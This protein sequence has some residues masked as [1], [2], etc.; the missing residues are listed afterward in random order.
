MFQLERSE[1]Q[2]LRCQIGILEKG[3]HAKYPP[4]VFT[5]EG[6][7]MLSSVLHSDRAIDVNIAIMRA[8]VRVKQLWAGHAEIIQKLKGLEKKLRR[9]G[10]QFREHDNQIRTIFNAIRQL[11]IPS[12]RPRQPIGFRK[13][14][15]LPKQ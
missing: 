6:V 7:S 1:Y 14:P 13:S 5:Q 11:M 3:R 15:T 2:T 9:H 12:E 10:R 8:F 4:Y